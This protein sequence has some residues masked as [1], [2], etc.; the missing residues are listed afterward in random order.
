MKQKEQKDKKK[1]YC[2]KCQ[3]QTDHKHYS[4]FGEELTLEDFKLDIP[5]FK[6]EVPD[7]KFDIPDIKLDFTGLDTLI[8]GWE[9]TECQERQGEEPSTH[10][11]QKGAKAVLTVK[12]QKPRGKG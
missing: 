4:L 11:K 2:K 8:E 6:F 9:C 10:K 1:L 7:F 12:K 5:D 3:E